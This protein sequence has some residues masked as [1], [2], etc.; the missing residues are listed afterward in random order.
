MQKKRQRRGPTIG[1][2]RLEML[3]LIYGDVQH[4]L[5]DVA[6]ERAKLELE[7]VKA[8]TLKAKA[9]AAE[10]FAKASGALAA[11]K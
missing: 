3:G 6:L 4:D 10:S 2:E 5:D 9:D 1:A 11:D 8:D 7:Q